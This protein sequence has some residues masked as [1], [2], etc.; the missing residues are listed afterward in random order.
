MRLIIFSVFA[1]D[2]SI[3]LQLFSNWPIFLLHSWGRKHWS[4]PFPYGNIS[5]DLV[6]PVLLDV[7]FLSNVGCMRFYCSMSG[8]IKSSSQRESLFT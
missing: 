5:S 8:I 2:D 1:T 6:V 4:V 3:P 7:S